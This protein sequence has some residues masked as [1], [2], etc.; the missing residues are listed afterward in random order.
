[1]NFSK[2]MMYTPFGECWKMVTRTE[3]ICS[4][5]DHVATLLGIK[6]LIYNSNFKH[7]LQQN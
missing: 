2:A 3:A 1:L 5:C 7:Y 4:K 6:G